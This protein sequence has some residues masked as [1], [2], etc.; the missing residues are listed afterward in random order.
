MGVIQ[1]SS[2]AFS[3]NE[4][5]SKAF[6]TVTRTGNLSNAST[7][8]Y[9]TL[10]G[11]ATSG[12]DYISIL[13]GKVFFQPGQSIKTI[14]IAV[15]NDNIAE[16]DETFSVAAG[17][18]V[19]TFLAPGQK[20]DVF[21]APRTAI[22]TIKD[23]DVGTG[24]TI[25]FSQS[26]F[27]VNEKQGFAAVTITKP[28]SSTPARVDFKTV[29]DYA[30]SVTTKP[31][32]R[33]YTGVTRTLSFAP[34]ETSKTVFV[35][36][37]NDSLPEINETFNVVLSNPVGISLGLRRNA[38]VTINNDD[39]VPGIFTQEVL[40][41]GLTWPSGFA[42]GHNGI[43]YIAETQGKLK[44]FNQKTKTL[45]P[46]PFIDMT[47]KVNSAG[48]R[49][50]LS[51]AVD[52]QFPAR[53]YI[54]LGYTYDPP[55]EVAKDGPDSM[56]MRTNRLVRVTANAATNYTTVVPNSE[57]VLMEVPKSYNFHAS[58]GLAFGK[59]GSLFWGHGDGA[60]VS[61]VI[62]DPSNLTNL[63]F[64]F[65][66]LYRINPNNGKGYANNP[67][68][69][70]NPD[71]VQ[72]K[73]YSWGLRN[74]FRIAIHPT[75]GEPYIGDVGFDNWEEV[76]TGRGKNFGWPLYEG[77]YIN[78]RGQNIRTPA[79]ANDPTKQAL[80][81]QFG[82]P[83]PPL[84]ARNHN[85]KFYSIIMGDFY[86]G[87][88]YPSMFQNSLFI[89]NFNGRTM[90]ALN[91][92][93]TGTKVENSIL[94]DGNLAALPTQIRLGPDGYLYATDYNYEIQGASSL[95][96]WVY[97]KA[98]PKLNISD[99]SVIEGNNG[100]ITIARF[101]LTL[102]T[103]FSQPAT[104]R[105]NT[106]SQSAWANIDY[107]STTG[108]LTFAPGTTVRTIEVPVRGD[109]IVEANE[110]FGLQLTQPVNMTLNKTK[111]VGTI[112]ENDK[113]I[114]ST[115]NLNIAEGQ[116]GL[117]NAKFVLRLSTPSTRPISVLVTTGNG[118][119]I[120]GNDYF[121]YNRVISFAP[122]VTLA[123][124]IVPIKG[125]RI[126]EANENFFLRLTNPI[127]ATVATPQVQGTMVNDDPKP[128]ISVGDAAVSEGNIGVRNAQFIVKLS[129]PSSQPVTAIATTSNSTAVAGTDYIFK[130]ELVYFAPGQ[131]SKVVAVQVRGDKIPEGNETFNLRL[132]NLTNANPGDLVG[133]GKIFNDDFGK[134]DTLLNNSQSLKLNNSSID[135]LPVSNS[136]ELGN[137]GSQRPQ[138]VF[139]EGLT[140]NNVFAADLN[141]SNLSI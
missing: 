74:P 94:F 64:P 25:G 93:T 88:A 31:Q 16:L 40:T 24:S 44:V 55:G 12:V 72:S 130:R 107:I 121:A 27:T 126:F 4:G 8:N 71:A 120:A 140:P 20:P 139:I 103:K 87:N 41:S 91:F 58:A 6:V 39:K 63:N 53:P 26:N 33:D 37:V 89:A 5:T 67:F 10:P 122:N 96:R 22:I 69:N 28:P 112:I 48:Q 97:D 45:L 105:Y 116:N 141:S 66:K 52:P 57:V 77:G 117:T 86:R 81:N 110:T 104:V 7:L 17:D 50:L 137:T 68:F 115:T 98:I 15:V 85:D 36:L 118:T 42:W 46:T 56:N 2:A 11:T 135:Y 111:A 62:F 136:L 127:N 123:T 18:P 106:G 75:T 43:M 78:G 13:N 32:Y 61:T 9:T 70:G 79:Y 82:T 99:P 129:A 113:A 124:A 95:I 102:D 3:T 35:P 119:A 30:K 19:T 80:Y 65:G 73:V 138:N 133:V 14:Q 114:I 59:D 21:G 47:N 134:S 29:D 51:L 49:G 100:A 38:T 90:E 132:T 23:N 125:D 83:T 76:N 101:V 60:S 131:V 34:F 84:Y 92:D 54:Y 108:V 1:L 109:N 128:Q